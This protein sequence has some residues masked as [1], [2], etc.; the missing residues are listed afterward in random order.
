MRRTSFASKVK[1]ELFAES[2][3]QYNNVSFA[4]KSPNTDMP[5]LR[6]GAIRIGVEG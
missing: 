1:K 3:V 6:V 4:R 5:P 2:M